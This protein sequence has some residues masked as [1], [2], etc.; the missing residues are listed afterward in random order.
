MPKFQITCLE[1]VYVERTYEVDSD[2]L[3]E[4]EDRV[5]YCDGTTL[6]DEQIGES[7]QY[8]GIQAVHDD[9]GNVVETKNDR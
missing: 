8:C 2:T 9:G 6:I 7:Y 3:A 5:R 4:A 1:L